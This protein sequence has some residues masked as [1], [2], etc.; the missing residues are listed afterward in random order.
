MLSAYTRGAHLG[1]GFQG[2]VYRV[3]RNSDGKQL[4]VK[5]LLANEELSLARARTEIEILKKVQGKRHL[6]QIVESCEMNNKVHIFM[7]EAGSLSLEALILDH[8]NGLDL[9]TTNGLFR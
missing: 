6:A 1:S 5:T 7:E 2:S 4:V 3:S 9:D 8:P